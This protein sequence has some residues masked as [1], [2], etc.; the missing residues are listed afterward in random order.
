M[1]YLILISKSL[2]RNKSLALKIIDKKYYFSIL[3]GNTK[4]NEKTKN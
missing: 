4:K 1:Q 2:L 3:G